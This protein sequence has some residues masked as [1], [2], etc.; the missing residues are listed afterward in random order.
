MRRCTSP[1]RAAIDAGGG[2]DEFALAFAFDA[3]QADDL[4]GVH[5]QIDLIEA[6]AAQAA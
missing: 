5:D 2:A 4:A 3:G 1:P 6:A